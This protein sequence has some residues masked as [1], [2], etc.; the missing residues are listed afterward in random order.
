MADGIPGRRGVVAAI[1]M[2]V[3]GQILAI[4]N[5]LALRQSDP[6]DIVLLGVLIVLAIFLLRRVR[7]ARWM[8]VVL[9]AAGGVFGLA[10]FVLLIATKIAP[11]LWS[12]VGAANP[13]LQSLHAATV[14]FTASR[15]FPLLAASVLIS[16]ALDLIAVAVLVFA[17]SVRSYFSSSASTAGG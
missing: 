6:S 4:A 17:P 9:V 2:M 5:D 15:A 14:A 16:A 10:G 11:G 8:T 1:A 12:G 7:W 13:A 3:A